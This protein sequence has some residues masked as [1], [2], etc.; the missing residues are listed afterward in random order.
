MFLIPVAHF[1]ERCPS[2]SRKTMLIVGIMVFSLAMGTATLTRNGIILDLVLGVAG[3]A[4]AAHVPITSSILTSIYDVPST[5]RHCV[6]TFFLAGGN[7]F[8]VVFGGLG[9]GVINVLFDGD[10]RGSFI[11]VAVLYAVVAI[12]VALAIPNVPRHYPTYM[13]SSASEDKYTLG[14][15]IKKRRA[16]AD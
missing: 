7:V 3:V 16:L 8:A 5:R 2:V 13:V 1:A 14:R 15:S 12:V 6:F 10:W 9:S 11:F 4:C